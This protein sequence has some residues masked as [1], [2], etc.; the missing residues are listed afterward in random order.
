MSPSTSDATSVTARFESSLPETVLEDATGASFTG[1][2]AIA[3]VAGAD[4]WIP[5]LTRKL[6]VSVPCQ[7]AFGV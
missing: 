4:D 1:A 7:F 6:N 5:S 3:I 2:T